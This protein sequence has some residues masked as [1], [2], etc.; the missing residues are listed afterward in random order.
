M[1]RKCCVGGCSS[2]YDSKFNKVTAYGFYKV[3]VYRFPVDAT[4][5]KIWVDGLPNV[6]ENVT[7]NIGICERHWSDNYPK[8]KKKR[9]I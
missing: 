7:D 3:T 6:I 9:K 8:V 5:C 4:E 2:G 1:C